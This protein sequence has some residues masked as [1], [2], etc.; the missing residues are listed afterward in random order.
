M[1]SEGANLRGHALSFSSRLNKLD[2][3]WGGMALAFAAATLPLYIYHSMAGVWIT[4]DARQLTWPFWTIIDPEHF[5]PDFVSAYMLDAMPDAFV[6]LVLSIAGLGAP[7]EAVMS[8]LGVV[9][10]LAC[11]VLALLTGRR[12]GGIETGWA[13][14]V[15]VLAI[16]A[17]A[18]STAGGLPRAIGWPAVFLAIYGLVCL[19]PIAT[20]T[21]SII[22]GLFWYPTAVMSGFLFAAQMLLPGAWIGR[23]STS[24][25]HK[26]MFVVALVGLVTILPTLPAL[27]DSDYGRILTA[28]DALWPEAMSGG[29]F[30]N[31]NLIGVANAGSDILNRMSNALVNLD[32][33]W[34]SPAWFWNR[35][36]LSASLA[37]LLGAW[38]VLGLLAP[39]DAAARRLLTIFVV[40]ALLYVLAILAAPYLYA[41]NRYLLYLWT[42]GAVIAAPFAAMRLKDA[43]PWLR[44]WL[45]SPPVTLFAAMAGL[46]L[47]GAGW[48]NKQGLYVNPDT[49]ERQVLAFAAR[50][51][52]G[53]LFAGWPSSNVINDLPYYSHRPVLMAFELHLP[54][55][56]E[57]LREAR[58][59]TYAII[60]AWFAP[61]PAG[62]VDLR[63]RYAVDYF[64]VDKHELD[65][66]A[67]FAP[68]DNRI[69]ELSQAQAAPPYI[70]NPDRAAVVFENARFAVLSSAR[71]ANEPP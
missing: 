51:P 67:Y 12:A 27:A 47:F 57:Y 4:D 19:R 24:S 60:D 49:E 35:I 46:I 25:L 6:G 22:G 15:L 5:P 58:A 26:R 71:L 70:R 1:L 59:R 56:E 55:R 20:A 52:P 2:L 63:R 45:P 38:L 37:A 62:I 40:G 48:L 17:V 21:A 9:C 14:F 8:A 32:G 3:L 66:A 23:T 44:R 54:F 39:R 36:A 10:L 34:R 61:T 33:T 68:Y 29:R 43:L 13:A 7:P 42:A 18:M 53:T 16:Q 41:P 50:T 28:S 11:A 65:G 31:E 30:A 64:I 69:R